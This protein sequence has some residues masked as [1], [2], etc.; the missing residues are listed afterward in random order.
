[1]E[2]HRCSSRFGREPSSGCCSSLSAAI[3]SDDG[4]SGSISAS[5]VKS[6]V[7]TDMG[8]GPTGASSSLFSGS[9]A[10]A[11]RTR[12]LLDC[13]RTK[14]D[15]MSRASWSRACP[16]AGD[17]PQTSYDV[18][19]LAST[20]TLLCSC[21]SGRRHEP[22]LALR[23]VVVIPAARACSAHVPEYDAVAGSPANSG[24]VARSATRRKPAISEPWKIRSRR[25]SKALASVYFGV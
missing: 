11:G 14:A 17:G 16:I 8:A 2:R 15:A 24:R 13:T 20:G 25:L 23:R 10:S 1:M 6:P 9:S 22:G 12:H 21:R 5:A 18:I 7:D 4:L 19:G 3:L